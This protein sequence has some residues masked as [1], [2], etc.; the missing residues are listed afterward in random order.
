[1]QKASRGGAPILVHIWENAGHGWAT[2]K[3]TGIAEHTEWL[4]FTMRHLGMGGWS[5]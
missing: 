4:A 1:M 5:A 3:S 2:D